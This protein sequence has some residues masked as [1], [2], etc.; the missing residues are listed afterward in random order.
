MMA[1][2]RVHMKAARIHYLAASSPY[3]SCNTGM[4]YTATPKK[5]KPINQKK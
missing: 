1:P 2:W 4:I 3:S 5:A